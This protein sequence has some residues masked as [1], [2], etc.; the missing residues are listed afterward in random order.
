MVAQAQDGA[1]RQDVTGDTPGF[2]GA[3]HANNANMLVLPA[4]SAPGALMQMYLWDP[5]RDPDLDEQPNYRPVHGGDDPSLVFHE[6]AHGLTNRL[7][8]DGSG[9]RRA[10]RGAGRGDRRGHGRLVRARL[11]GRATATI[12]SCRTTGAP[13]T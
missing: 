9:L 10:E 3:H 8:T 5:T 12:P 13:R 11:P 2:P 4:G 7:V 1:D 6:Y